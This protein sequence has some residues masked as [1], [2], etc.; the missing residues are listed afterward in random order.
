[1]PVPAPA[2]LGE[3]LSLQLPPAT[4]VDW[5]YDVVT[6][7]KHLLC[8]SYVGAVDSGGYARVTG[9]V[10][11]PVA[12]FS[13]YG[14]D[15]GGVAL[16]TTSEAIGDLSAGSNTLTLFSSLPSPAPATAR[17][18]PLAPATALGVGSS[19]SGS[20]APCERRYYAF[21]AVAGQAY[22]VKVTAEFVGS[23]RVRKVPPNG[24]TTIRTDPPFSVNN[25]GGTPLALAAGVERVVTFTIP[26]DA[27][28]GS[29]TYIVEVDADLDGAGSYSLSLASP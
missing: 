23:V 15:L 11:G 16:G 3:L 13:N 22:T 14:G 6:A 29:G 19:G 20:I 4:L 8:S 5:R 21:A 27:A 28:H 25:V 2:A 18:V 10:W 1:M 12:R 17:L 24:D 7:G 26:S 9:I